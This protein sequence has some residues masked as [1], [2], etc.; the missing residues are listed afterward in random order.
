MRAVFSLAPGEAGVAPNNAHTRV[1]L[2]RVVAQSPSD[3]LLRDQ[4]LNSGFD[5]I[6]AIANREV[7]DI[8]LEWYDEL[9]TRMHLKWERPPQTGRRT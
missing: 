4:F 2:V 3:D 7:F 5:G 6:G 8:F 9:E 1:Y